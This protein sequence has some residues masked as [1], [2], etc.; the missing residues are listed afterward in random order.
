VREPLLTETM[1]VALV[2]PDLDAAMRTY[3]DD[4]GIG[5]WDV[6]EFNGDT[7]QNL[8]QRGEPI[9]CAWRLALATVGGVQ[10]ELIEPLDDRSIYAEFL[11]RNRGPGVHHVGVASRGFDE[12]VAEVGRTVLL[13]GEYNGIRFAYLETDGDLGVITEIFDGEPGADQQPDATYP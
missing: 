2:V 11:T 10:W 8:R 4:Y 12:T 9:D 6:Y 3:V 7:V 13:E 1:Q 5:P